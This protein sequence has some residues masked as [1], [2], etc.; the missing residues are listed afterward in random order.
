LWLFYKSLRNYLELVNPT[1]PA[2]LLAVPPDLLPLL[3]VEAS[4]SKD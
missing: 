4:E 2:A 3:S 1:L